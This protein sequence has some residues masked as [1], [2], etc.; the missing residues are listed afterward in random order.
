MD[1]LKIGIY[2][3]VFIPQRKQYKIYN[4]YKNTLKYERVENILKW[5]ILF[6]IA[7]KYS[8]NTKAEEL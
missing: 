2:I 7:T 6:C 1:R 5:K 3:E 8:C 4:Y